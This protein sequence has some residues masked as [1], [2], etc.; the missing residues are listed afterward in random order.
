MI[1][2]QSPV[3]SVHAILNQ[4]HQM[5]WVT[6]DPFLFCVHHLDRYPQG[7]G[8]LGISTSLSGKMWA[9]TSQEKMD[10][11]CTMG[12]QF[13]DFHLIHIRVLKPL[14][15]VG[16]IHRSLR[17]IGAGSIWQGRRTLDD[18]RKGVVHSR[19]FP[20]INTAGQIQ[21]TVSD[22]AQSTC[23]DKMVDPY[24]TMFLEDTYKS[25]IL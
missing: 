9:V 11:L 7:D 12:R 15:S 4:V 13:L 6:L 25:S 14:Q 2:S 22:L 18:R 16:G 1:L 20:L 19:I 24:F 10:G 8:K 23:Q 17:L 21:P 5:P 3:W